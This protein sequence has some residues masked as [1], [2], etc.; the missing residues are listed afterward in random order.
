MLRT[1][2]STRERPAVNRRSFLRGLVGCGCA[3]AIPTFSGCTLSEIFVEPKQGAVGFDLVESRFAPLAE[4]GGMVPI[5]LGARKVLLVR[6]TESEVIALDRI[7]THLGCDMAPEREGMWAGNA[8]VC[9]CHGSRFSPVGQVIDG[10]ASSDLVAHE[11]DFDPDTGRGTLFV[12]VSQEAG[13]DAGA[14][15][16]ADSGESEVDAG[17]TAA[18]SEPPEAPLVRAVTVDPETR[19]FTLFVADE[20]ALAE[21]G[22]IRAV[23]ADGRPLVVIHVETLQFVTLSRLCT[24]RQCDMAP[25]SLGTF[26]SGELACMCH[27]SR[28]AP[29]GTVIQGPAREPL[30]GFATTFE[31]DTQSIVV[32]IPEDAA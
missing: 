1:H 8:L 21:V 20:P 2:G 32:E 10:P 22:G 30:A 19:T 9:R 25:H 14:D 13:T 26:E 11:V 17:P 4:V 24:H 31:A 23:D 6:H 7:C 5:D 16:P 29:D 15:S 3:A 28:F 27:G 12:G 18:D